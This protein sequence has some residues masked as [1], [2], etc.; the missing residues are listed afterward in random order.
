[1]FKKISQSLHAVQVD[2]QFRLKTSVVVKSFFCKQFIRPNFYYFSLCSSFVY[3]L[4]RSFRNQFNEL[5]ELLEDL[6]FETK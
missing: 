5:L 1:M 4:M 2:K 6:N 3:I